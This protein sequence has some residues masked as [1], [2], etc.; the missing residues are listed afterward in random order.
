MQTMH[1]GA[2]SRE[3]T[4]VGALDK[5]IAGWVAFRPKRVTMIRKTVS[6]PL[7]G[8]SFRTPLSYLAIA[9][10]GAS[11][12]PEPDVSNPEPV[13]AHPVVDDE[14]VPAD[15]IVVDFPSQGYMMPTLAGGGAQQLGA[16][17]CRDKATQKQLYDIIRNVEQ[18]QKSAIANIP[19]LEGKKSLSGKLE[20]ALSF[21]TARL[22]VGVAA[23]TSGSRDVTFTLAFGELQEKVLPLRAIEEELREIAK[24]ALE[25]DVCDES[26]VF[27]IVSVITAKEVDMV[28]DDEM[29]V[30]ADL[31]A[32]LGKIAEASAAFKWSKEQGL[33]IERDFDDDVV[34]FMKL[35]HFKEEGRG[36]V[37]EQVQ[38]LGQDQAQEIRQQ[39]QQQQQ[40]QSWQQQ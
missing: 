26:G 10:L 31:D 3:W 21:A 1:S 9:A 32:E 7:V 33:K 38:Q 23:G 28:F 24:A 37:V 17:F 4:L 39:Q 12:K 2:S 5:P 14:L 22:P 30:G 19:E 25:S 15:E 13:P 35:V 6:S 8:C 36:V 11:C 16:V 29:E 18:L 34:F 20:L 27:G 40:Q